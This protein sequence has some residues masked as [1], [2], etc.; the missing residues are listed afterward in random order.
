M[1]DFL[2]NLGYY[3]Y[4]RPMMIYRGIRCWFRHNFNKRHLKTVREAIFGNPFDHGYLWNLELAKLDEMLAYF[5]K[6]DIVE[7]RSKE[8]DIVRTLRWARNMLNIVVK[9]DHWH[10]EGEMDFENFS[11]GTFGI[12]CDVKV[13]TKNIER[14]V[15]E[16]ETLGYLALTEG[17]MRDYEEYVRGRVK[18]LQER[19]Y[20]AYL[21]KARVLYHKIRMKYEE[22]WW[23]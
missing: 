18:I 14:Y 20:E 12:V 1:N 5:E 11:D 9:D 17:K 2:D 7:E 10:T 22:Y 19:P 13:N 21:I 23:D 4:Y 15:R 16:A 6:S 8:S 3:V